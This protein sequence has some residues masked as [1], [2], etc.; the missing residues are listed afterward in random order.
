M[1]K[2]EEKDPPV[3]TYLEGVS[4]KRVNDQKDAEEHDNAPLADGADV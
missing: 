3:P 4:L 1:T 2:D